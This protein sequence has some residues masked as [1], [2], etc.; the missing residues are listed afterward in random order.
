LDNSATRGSLV[1]AAF[2]IWSSIVLD[3]N[4]ILYAIVTLI[5]IFLVL[6]TFHGL[7]RDDVNGTS[8][9]Q[10]EET[11]ERLS[12]PILVPLVALS[13]IQSVVYGFVTISITPIIL[14]AVVKAIFWISLSKIVSLLIRRYTFKNRG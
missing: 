13:A 2:A 10:L 4:T 11:L 6:A 12:W 9:A 8:S 1:V 14:N 3:R 5:A 7:S